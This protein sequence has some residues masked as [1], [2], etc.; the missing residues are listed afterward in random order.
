MDPLDMQR[1]PSNTPGSNSVIL[2]RAVVRCKEVA[3]TSAIMLALWRTDGD[4]ARRCFRIA[5]VEDGPFSTFSCGED[6][7]K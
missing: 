3:P 2:S 1:P 5:T 7:R 6:G 4:K